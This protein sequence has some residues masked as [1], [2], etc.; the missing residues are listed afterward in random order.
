M[1]L[2]DLRRGRFTRLTAGVRF[3]WTLCA[4]CYE[5]FSC[6]EELGKC[7]SDSTRLRAPFS[8]YGLDACVCFWS[9]APRS[10]S[11]AF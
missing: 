7:L 3:G 8:V 5:D 4:G 1:T 6:T 9:P 2:Q 11:G 10:F